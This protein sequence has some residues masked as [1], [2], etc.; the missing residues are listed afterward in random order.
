MN[1]NLTQNLIRIGA[2]LVFQAGYRITFY[3][4][5]TEGQVP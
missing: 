2:S 4:H 3:V 1:E 5:W